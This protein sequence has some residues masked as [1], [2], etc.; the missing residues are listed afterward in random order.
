M[1]RNLKIKKKKTIL[2]IFNKGVSTLFCKIDK[3][4]EL[5]MVVQF[6]KLKMHVKI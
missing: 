4:V 5:V 1:Q 2:L 6:L 3:T